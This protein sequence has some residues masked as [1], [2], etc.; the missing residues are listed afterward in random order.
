MRWSCPMP[1]RTSLTSASIFSHRLAISLMKLI[2]V[3]SSAL[4]TYLVI[5]ALSGDMT[6]NGLSVRRNGEY[7]SRRTSL[8]F[9][10]VAHRRRR[11]RET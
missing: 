1:R 7:S 6:R 5:S 3:D 8:D 2:F 10:A 11:G 9:A 4:A